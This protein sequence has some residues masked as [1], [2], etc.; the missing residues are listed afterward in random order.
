MLRV[1]NGHCNVIFLVYHGNECS[2]VFQDLYLV[3]RS[4]K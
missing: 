4:S 3:Q 1:I 2:D